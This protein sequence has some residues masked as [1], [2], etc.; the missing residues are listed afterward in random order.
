M[1]LPRRAMVR[2]KPILTFSSHTHRYGLQQSIVSSKV[3]HLPVDFNF[4]GPLRAGFVSI[5]SAEPTTIAGKPSVHLV[6]LIGYISKIFNTVIRPIVVNMVNLAT[7]PTAVDIQPGKSC[8][9]V[10]T[11]VYHDNPVP[12]AINIPSRLIF[13]PYFTGLPNNNPSFWGVMDDLFEVFL[14]YLHNG[15]IPRWRLNQ[16]VL[17]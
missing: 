10:V 1:I 2:V 14:G 4:G 13:K 17:T 11:A 8:A 7:W 12:L 16:N 6:L 3:N 15:S 9:S 5:N